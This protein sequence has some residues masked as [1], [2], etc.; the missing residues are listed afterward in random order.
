[1]LQYIAAAAS[2]AK[3]GIAEVTLNNPFQQRAL[4]YVM[5]QIRGP[6]AEYYRVYLEHASLTL[7]PGDSAKVKVMLESM[8]GDPSFGGDKRWPEKF[9][10]EPTRVSL[11]GYGVNLNNPAH[12]ILLGG[13]QIDVSSA[14]ATEFTKFGWDSKE[15]VVRGQVWVTSPS[16]PASGSVLLTFHG[17]DET[18]GNTVAVSLDPTGTFV[19]PGALEWVDKFRGRQ[20]T[21]HYPGRPGY[22]PSDAEPTLTV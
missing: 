12:P 1:M 20:I 18:E 16:G 6:F 22:G 21:G 14:W 19:F 11:V 2:P 7:D 15:G 3:R 17:P 13:A 4:I 10:Y 9:F 5:P 8:F